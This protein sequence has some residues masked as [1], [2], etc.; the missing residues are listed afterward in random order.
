MERESKG[1][2]KG[3]AWWTNE[4]RDAVEGEKRA[5]KK[6]L[7][8][9][10]PEEVKARKSEYKKWK[11]KVQEL[12]GESRRK[13]DEEFGRKL[14]QN[15]SEH[16]KMFWKE[17]KNVR[18]REGVSGVRV[19]GEDGELVGDESELNQI[20]KGYFEELMNNEAEGGSGDD[21]SGN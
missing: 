18:G 15:F 17:G 19:R 3:S 5:Y 21:K 12:I 8:R 7:Q 6:M 16:K 11:K 2:N 10:L 20:W 9:N 13:V 14:S 1:K 4:I